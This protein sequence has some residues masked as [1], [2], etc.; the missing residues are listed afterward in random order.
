VVSHTRVISFSEMVG[1]LR[2][3]F[4]KADANTAEG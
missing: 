1:R 4:E 2:R 3:V